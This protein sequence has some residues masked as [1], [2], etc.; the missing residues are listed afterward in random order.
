MNRR[1]LTLVLGL[2][3]VVLLVA[4]AGVALLWPTPSEAERKAGLIRERMTR[5]EVSKVL[6]PLP[7][8]AEIL[9]PDRVEFRWWQDDTSSIIIAFDSGL[10]VIEVRTLLPLFPPPPVHPLTRLRRT[11]ARVLPFLGE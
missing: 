8:A 7:R 4:G 2:A 6:G 11:F 3:I 1:R 10:G 5:S 9:L